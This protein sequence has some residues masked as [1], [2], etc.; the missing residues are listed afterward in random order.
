MGRGCRSDLLL[1]AAAL[2][3][4]LGYRFKVSGISLRGISSRRNPTDHD[5]HAD[6][7]PA[8]HDRSALADGPG[9][10]HH[11]I[12]TLL[13]RFGTRTRFRGRAKGRCR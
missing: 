2:R 7:P 13:I 5:L 6:S 8:A 12:D 4:P 10:G 1:D 11:D 3:S 9:R